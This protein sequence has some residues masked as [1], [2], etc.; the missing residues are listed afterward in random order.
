[1]A[2]KSVVLEVKEITLAIELIELG[3]RLQLLE[4]ETSL[5][6]D[7][8]IKLYKELKG[9]SPPKGMLPFSTD[10]FMTWQPNIHSSLF[11]NIYRFM[12]Q[13]GCTEPIRAV[14]KS[15]R[16]YLEHTAIHGDEPLLSLTRAWTL[17]RFFE[18]GMLQLTPCVRCRG[19]FVAH[20]HD[21]QS[22]FVCG[23]CQPPSRAGKT[24]KSGA[25]TAETGCSQLA[26]A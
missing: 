3:A 26:A 23:L 9:V 22:G 14:V 21:P 15:Y 5:S 6:R 7:R 16:L 24:K 2:T 12:A 10:W 1:M 13:H 20:A 11:Y 8:L 18:S 19:N 25:K 4:A 17:V